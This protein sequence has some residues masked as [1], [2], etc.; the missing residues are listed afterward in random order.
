M[1]FN[2]TLDDLKNNLK[3]LPGVGDKT[4]QR[5]ALHLLTQSKE[6]SLQFSDV[7]REAVEIHT[8]CARCNLLSDSDPCAICLDESRD[9]SLICVVENSYDVYLVENTGEYKGR[10]FVLGHLLSPI[11]G[12]GIE[13]IN[14]SHLL[15][16]ANNGLVKEIILAVNPSTE[17]ET[18][19]SL[20][21][22]ELASTDIIVTRLSTGL[23]FG[24]N[25]EYSSQLTLSN[26]IRR[27]YTI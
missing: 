2:K 10:Y 25:I 11:D 17:G 21:A 4:A 24:A 8:Y 20:I 26:A 16:V 9:E 1:K 22:G 7:I 14:L 23:P 27:R 3:Q 19:M 12:I 15:E 5:Y 18:T 6:R 13:E